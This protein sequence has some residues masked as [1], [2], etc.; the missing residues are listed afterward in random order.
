M[1][2]HKRES[3]Q[4]RN[5]N[6]HSLAKKKKGVK[7]RKWGKGGGGVRRRRE[8]G[9]G[10]KNTDK[11]RL[12]SSVKGYKVFSVAEDKASKKMSRIESKAA[13]TER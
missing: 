1:K 12:D 11:D 4:I 2:R 5:E 3:I 8:G 6:L 7:W 10:V 13:C 9:G